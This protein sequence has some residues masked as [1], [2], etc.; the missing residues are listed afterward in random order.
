MELT[1][2]NVTDKKNLNTFNNF[3]CRFRNGTDKNQRYGKKNLKTFHAIII[4][5]RNG[6]VKI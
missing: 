6:T 2:T 4:R 3:F 5:M 1:K